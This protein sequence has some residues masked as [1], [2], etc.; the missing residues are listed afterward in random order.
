MAK[1]KIHAANFPL[2]EMSIT[3]GSLFIKTKWYQMSGDIIL[4]TDVIT[5]EVASEDSV[6]KVGGAMGWGVVGG[7][8]MGPVGLIAGVLLGGNKKDVTFI[9][10]LSGERK[11][12]ATTD[13]KTFISFQARSL[14]L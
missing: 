12:M 1:I 11:F 9:V 5:V 6:K 4:T 13:S 7:A 2:E 3:S 10:E 14:K 8:L